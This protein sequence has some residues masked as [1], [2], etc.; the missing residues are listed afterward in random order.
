MCPVRE[1][2]DELSLRLRLLL[3][4]LHRLLHLLSRLTL[5]LGGLAAFLVHLLGE[6]LG[7][8][9]AERVRFGGVGHGVRNSVSRVAFIRAS[10]R[11]NQP[12][13]ATT[14]EEPRFFELVTGVRERLAGRGAQVEPEL[15]EE[16][17]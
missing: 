1:P 13:T 12:R 9:L 6:L 2:R 4:L 5:L 11:V 14:G 16:T 7:G 17:P 15:L 8:L 3:H 10:E